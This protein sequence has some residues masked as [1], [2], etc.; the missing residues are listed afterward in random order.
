[1]KNPK[2]ND[3][4]TIDVEITLDN[5]E[6]ALTTITGEDS[7]FQELVRGDFGE[8]AP[9]QLPTPTPLTPL[10]IR[11]AALADI[12]YTRPLDGVQIQIRHPDYASDYVI[13]TSAISMLAPSETRLWITK[14]NQ[15]TLV[16]R[17]DLEAAIAFGNVEVDRIFSEYITT[18][19]GE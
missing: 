4:G 10:Q 13:M 3:I 12:T 9:W 18:L 14:D 8:V 15:P 6:K 16:S 7:R 17:E 19:Q 11:K 2:Y 5:G 1:M